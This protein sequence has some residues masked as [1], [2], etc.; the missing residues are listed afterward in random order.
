MIS[1][2]DF[3]A[4][5]E[6]A[7]AYRA[8]VDELFDRAEV[9]VAVRAAVKWMSDRPEPPAKHEQLIAEIVEFLQNT[10]LSPSQA[11][12]LECAFFNPR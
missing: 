5:L 4:M 1:D 8:R 2:D 6:S 11:H 9:V 7:R 3:A 10:R 12:E